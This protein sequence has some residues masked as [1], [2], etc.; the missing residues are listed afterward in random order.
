MGRRSPVSV[1]ASFADGPV[2]P[3]KILRKPAGIR[4][5][6][7]FTCEKAVNAGC[8]HSAASGPTH[9]IASTC[10]PSDRSGLR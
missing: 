3:V 7:K 1:R 10:I 4:K 2:R 8:F 5:Y 9:T 6:G